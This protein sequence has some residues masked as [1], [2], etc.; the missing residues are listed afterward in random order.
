MN[1]F[2]IPREVQES[3]KPEGGGV[4]ISCPPIYFEPKSMKLIV[5]I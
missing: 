3:N 1:F 5:N 4:K 2:V